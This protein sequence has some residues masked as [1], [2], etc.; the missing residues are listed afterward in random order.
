MV[1]NPNLRAVEIEEVMQTSSYTYLKLREVNDVYWAAISRR[2]DLEEGETYYFDN[3]MEQKNFPSKELGRTFESILFI[4]YISDEPFSANQPAASAK[5]GSSRVGNMEIEPMEPAEGGITLAELFRNRQ[6]YDGEVVIVRGEVV[7]FT[8]AVMK[9]NWVHI[10]DG[11]A[12]GTK[13]DL[14]ITTTESVSQ[15]DVVT[16]K[17]KVIL[18]KDF[19]HGYSYEVLMEDAVLK[20]IEKKVS[21]Q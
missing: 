4:Q 7:K 11:T 10:Q 17:G 19:G 15:G 18:D 1:E 12:Y 16:F 13:F 14:T 2:D 21:L 8:S 5:K 20:K 6:D 3:W 9:R